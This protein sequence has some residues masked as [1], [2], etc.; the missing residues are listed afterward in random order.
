MTPVTM[1]IQLLSAND[2]QLMLDEE[3]SKYRRAELEASNVWFKVIGEDWR[4][5]DNIDIQI[6]SGFRAYFGEYSAKIDSLLSG[7]QVST[8]WTVVKIL[9]EGETK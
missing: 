4:P 9:P 2:P 3:K 1:T 8:C 6:I 5:V 7:E